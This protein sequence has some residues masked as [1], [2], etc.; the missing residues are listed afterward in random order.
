[1]CA[2]TSE[3][4]SCRSSPTTSPVQ[5]LTTFVTGQ[6][7]NAFGVTPIMGRAISDADAPIYSPGAR[8][9]LISHRLWTGTFAADPAVLGRSLQVN[10]VDVAI[11]G[12]LPRGF[13][14]L[15][16]DHGVDI[17]TTFDS[18]LAG[19][20]PFVVNWPASSSADCVPV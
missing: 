3:A 1:M 19:R 9:A 17:F 18:V 7:F 20:S 5:T 6:C 16:V 13:V 14:G 4:S 10:N 12:V 15:E 2:A 11:I 8:V